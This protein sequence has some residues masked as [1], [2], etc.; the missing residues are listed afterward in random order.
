MYLMSP[1]STLRNGKNGKFYVTYILSKKKRK[2]SGSFEYFLGWVP[3]S[4]VEV[5]QDFTVS[6][7]LIFCV[8]VI[9]KN[10]PSSFHQIPSVLNQTA[11]NCDPPFRSF[12]GTEWRLEKKKK[13]KELAVCRGETGLMA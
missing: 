1:N 5:G 3:V 7:R 10:K 11:N 6:Q 9:F 13:K 2:K 8:C 4:K 12:H